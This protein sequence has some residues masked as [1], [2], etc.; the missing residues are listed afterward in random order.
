MLLFHINKILSLVLG[1]EEEVLTYIGD[2]DE[3]PPLAL[4]LEPGDGVATEDMNSGN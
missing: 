1:G 2:G 3:D 4:P